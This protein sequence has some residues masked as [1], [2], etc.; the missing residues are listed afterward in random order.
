M[1]GKILNLMILALLPITLSM[2][3]KYAVDFPT[4]A[5]IMAL[6]AVKANAST[7][8][9]HKMALSVVVANA[10][11]IAEMGKVF[12]RSTA[13]HSKSMDEI[14]K[15]MTQPKA[16]EVL[17]K[18]PTIVN[19]STVNQFKGLLTSSQNLRKQ[20]SEQEGF[21]GLDGARKLLNGM[22]HEVML[23]YDAEIAKCTD[24]YA[25]QCA[26]MEAARGQISAA[27]YVAAT[28]RA[29]ILDSQGSINHCEASIPETTKELTDHKRKCK[30]E[31]S[32]M[33]KN[34]KIIMDDIAIM[35]MILEMSDC[36]KKKLLQTKKLTM[37]KCEDKCT[38]KEYVTFNHKSLQDRV[39]EL[40]LPGMQELMTDTFADLFDD[41]EEEQT[42]QLVQVP[43]SEYMEAVVD[44]TDLLQVAQDPNV[45]PAPTKAP[46]KKMKFNNPPLPKTKVPSNPCTDKNQGAPSAANKRAAKCTL[47]KS[48]RCYKLQ[49][50]FL[51]IQ[52]EI[53]D[54]RDALMEL[55]STT[56]A[57]CEETKTA[58]ETSIAGDSALLSS[59]QTKLAT[60]TE[61]EAG[62]AEYGRQ[63]GME[64][65]QYNADLMKQ[66]KTCN[67]NYVDYETDL[68]ALKKIRGDVFKKMQ[69]GHT[70]FFQDCELSPWTP[71]ACSAK[72]AGGNQKLTRSVAAHPN[73][74]SKCLPLSAKKRCN[75]SPCP[76]NCALRQ[77]SGWS[78]CSSKCG[79]GLSQR[80]RDVMIPV[81]YGGKQCGQTGETKQCNVDACE[82][83]CV[84]QPWTRWTACSKDCDGGSRKRERMIREPVEGGGKC[85][86]KWSPERLQYTPCA[87]HRCKVT[88]ASK[89]KKCDQKLDLVLVVD[90]TP[91]NGQRGFDAEIKAVNL[92]V[93]AFEGKDGQKSN[94]NFAIVHYTGPRTWSGV[95]MCTGKTSKQV[96]METTCKV[97]LAQHF[98]NDLATTRS[99]VN[100]LK[101]QPGSKLLSLALMTT[102]F[103]FALGDKMARTVVV[104]FMDGQPLSYRKTNLASR[105]VRKKA[106][107]LYVVV[108][109]FAPL[110]HIKTW[111]SR[112]WQENLIQVKS[113]EQLA[114]AEVGTHLVANICPSMFPK[115]KAPSLKKL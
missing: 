21:G 43:G 48:P 1:A 12:D 23:K 32:K 11:A 15:L 69:P 28:A 96:D 105:A 88:D 107:L 51:Q 90:G 24:Y 61:K 76:V 83:D 71:E 49:A 78:R 56:D 25:K 67:A 100:G 3:M 62:A 82:K 19:A 57:S 40:K 53:M 55:I 35:T 80:V 73:G 42:V 72:C 17:K 60:A 54:S 27:N 65:D 89:V 38:K 4:D 97:K 102:Q 114:T 7:D 106:R 47:K 94:S 20:V 6:S 34:L 91:K 92:F 39:N 79:G 64:N 10:T 44:E 113:L 66:M 98:N 111:V 31:L 101:Y 46:P 33:N 14:S 104:V 87:M 63:I 115:L 18:I 26:L 84:L 95:S 59:S 109:K 36:D 8:N 75:L 58:L 86:D 50:R 93:D 68:C 16:L 112:R 77:W 37:L 110:K 22:I 9:P 45:T 41:G 30:G 70:G 5:H 13:V 2:K 85:A 103:E 108:A 99:T 52:A 29:L 81:Q 74:G